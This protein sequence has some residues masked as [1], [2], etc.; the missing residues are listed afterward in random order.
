ME[1]NY[2]Y[3]VKLL[4]KQC[5]FLF[6]N[7]LASYVAYALLKYDKETVLKH[8]LKKFTTNTDYTFC[9]YRSF[10][11][12]L[13]KK[14]NEFTQQQIEELHEMFV[15]ATTQIQDLHKTGSK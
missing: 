2:L 13:R 7:G 5:Q 9:N 4:N 10:R 14:T 8:R 6:P 1:N 12:R 3:P 11:I 15:S